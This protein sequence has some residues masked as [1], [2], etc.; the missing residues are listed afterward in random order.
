MVE[1]QDAK[2]KESADGNKEEDEIIIGDRKFY[3]REKAIEYARQLERE[4]AV[5]K[6]YVDGQRDL[7]GKQEESIQRPIEEII[8]EKLFEDPKA[9]VTELTQ[10]VQKQMESQFAQREQA[11][12]WEENKKQ[13]WNKF[14]EMHP[15][16]SNNKE[17][18]EY[19][20]NSKQNE[21][22]EMEVEQGLAKLGE[23]S[24]KQLSAFVEA[25]KPQK[26]MP[27]GAAITQQDGGMQTVSTQKEIEKHIDF[28]SQLRNAKKKKA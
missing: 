2:P 21:L 9:A 26:I 7:V 11:I 19:V 8:E 14:Y 5:E 28:V 15:E 13:T 17:L 6:A 27:S 10:Y 18:V 24:R 3:D 1:Q 23:L 16:L 12:Q 25:S 22:G 4:V 20:W